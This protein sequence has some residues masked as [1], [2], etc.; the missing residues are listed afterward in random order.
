MVLLTQDVVT[1][2]NEA[3]LWPSPEDRVAP[4]HSRTSIQLAKK[5]LSR[6]QKKKTFRRPKGG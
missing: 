1:T 5:L 3:Y 2:L 4:F 6:N